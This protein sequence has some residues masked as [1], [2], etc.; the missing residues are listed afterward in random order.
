MK[1]IKGLFYAIASSTTFGLI[2]LFALPVLVSGNINT[3]SILFYRFFFGFIIMGILGLL[4]GKS[5]RITWKELLTLFL[6]GLNYVLT[7]LGLLYSYKMVPSGMATTIHSLYPITVTLFSVLLFKEKLSINYIFAVVASILGVV[8]MCWS[9]GEVNYWGIALVFMTVFTYTNYIIL[10]SR[11]KVNRI[12]P[13]PLNFFILAFGAVI[14]Y[15]VSLFAPESQID[16][17]TTQSDLI[18]LVL[19][20]LVPTVISNI[21]LI[22]AVKSVGATKTAI[23][24]SFEPATAVLVGVFMFAEKINFVGILGF[25]LIVCATTIVILSSKKES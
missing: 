24:G 15:V 22:M 13:M 19:L 7:A 4:A 10:M 1:N 16:F 8:M 23:L 6:F 2:P 25:V 3:L 14:V 12:D 11:A 18:N 9:G 20:A 5:F 21:T 17:I